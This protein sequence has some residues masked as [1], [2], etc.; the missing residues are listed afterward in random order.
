M[1]TENFTQSMFLE[2]IKSQNSSAYYLKKAL[3]FL[4]FFLLS[5]F[6]VKT[7]Y[8]QTFTASITNNTTATECS[9]TPYPINVS[10]SSSGYNLTGVFVTY[11]RNGNPIGQ[12]SGRS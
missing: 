9:D 10:V 7:S 12:R 8:G 2:S 1:K 5:F 6:S 4:L 3:R 11:Y